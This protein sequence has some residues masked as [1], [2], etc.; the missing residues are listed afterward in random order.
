MGPDASAP[1]YY[2]ERTTQLVEAVGS[3][4]DA[5]PGELLEDELIVVVAGPGTAREDLVSNVFFVGLGGT[6]EAVKLPYAGQSLGR[7]AECPCL[8]RSDLTH[9]SQSLALVGKRRDRALQLVDALL[10]P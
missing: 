8:I 1:D 3:E 2:H 9:P 7:A 6:A 4:E 5:V 10:S